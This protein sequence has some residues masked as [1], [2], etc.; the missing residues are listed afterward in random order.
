VN[1]YL[2][3]NRDFWGEVVP[4]H[5]RSDFYNLPAFKAGETSLTPI[6]LEELGDVAGKSL[7][8]LQCHFGLDTLSWARRGARVTG[9]DF[10]EDA[11]ALA[12]D[13][14]RELG[15]P[16][17]F[18]CA[19]LYDL[20]D[21]L[22]GAFDIVF[23]S[24]GVLC[25]LP[26]LPRWGQ[27]VAHFLKPGGTFYL[28]EFHPF[29]QIFDDN[30]GVTDLR[31][32]YPYFHSPEPLVFDE[33]GSYA[34][35]TA[36]LRNRQTYEWSHSLADIL[37]ALLGA[38]LRLEFLH[39]FPFCAYQSLPLLRQDPDGWWRLPNGPDLVPLM[40]SLKAMKPN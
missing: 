9:A 17:E 37:N 29:G 26:D 2:K 30:E 19:N 21:V 8:H 13:L 27:I 28:V 1:D 12:H 15:I 35:R 25:W 4:I 5:A 24:Y 31:P 23:T 22:T 16:A 34:D 6:E 20:A 39:E 7:L 3:A 11:I 32:H 18:V 33:A 10:S 40:F 36:D 14:S 38:G